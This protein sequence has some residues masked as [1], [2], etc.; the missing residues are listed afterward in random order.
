MSAHLAEA[1]LADYRADRV[2]GGKR[3]GRFRC[4]VDL[5]G[6]LH[7]EGLVLAGRDRPQGATVHAKEADRARVDNTSLTSRAM[8]D[9]PECGILTRGCPRPR[10]ICDYIT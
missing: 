5:L 8:M 10:A 3:D 4:R 6:P 9:N 1:D 2:P 7:G